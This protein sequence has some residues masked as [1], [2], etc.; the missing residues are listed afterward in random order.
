MYNQVAGIGGNRL[1][2]RECRRREL[3]REHVIKLKEVKRREAM[4]S[5]LKSVLLLEVHKFNYL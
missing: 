1:D 5:K 3:K 2:D 4:C